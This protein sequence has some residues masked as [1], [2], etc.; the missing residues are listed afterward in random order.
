MPIDPRMIRRKACWIRSLLTM[1]LI[2]LRLISP[3]IGPKRASRAVARAPSW[4]PVGGW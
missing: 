2:E 3:S 1:P 4:P